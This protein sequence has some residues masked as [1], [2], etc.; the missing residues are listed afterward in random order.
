MNNRVSLPAENSSDKRQKYFFDDD[1]KEAGP[2][3]T[4]E[5]QHYWFDGDH[6]RFIL[7]KK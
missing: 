7:G 2:V 5:D 6:E 3:P 4:W 1:G